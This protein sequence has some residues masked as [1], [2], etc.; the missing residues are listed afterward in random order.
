MRTL[1]DHLSTYA[2]YHRDRRN[3]ATHFV[4]VPMIVVGILTA[5]AR[6][7]LAVHGLP[8]SPAVL[9]F[10]L[11]LAFYFRLDLRFGLAMTAVMTPALWLGMWLA[12]DA[13]LSWMISAGGLFFVGWLIQFVGHAYE[14]RKPAFVDDIAGLLVGPL[15]V[16]AE[17]AFAL[18]LCTELR[19]R[20]EDAV[21][22]TGI[23]TGQEPLATR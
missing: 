23:R 14:G 18:G 4:G 11:G 1:F 5:L 16:M 12:H 7:T 17:T 8:L 22:P 13:G 3:I 21:G 15:F 6:P 2:A 20:I 19:A 10:A 9:L